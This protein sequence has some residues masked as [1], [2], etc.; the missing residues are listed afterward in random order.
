MKLSLS[1]IVLAFLAV[2]FEAHADIFA[3]KDLKGFEACL[4][5]DNLKESIPA[6]GAKQERFLDQPEIQQR[7]VQSAAKILKKGNPTSA[8]ILEFVKTT[9][10]N[11]AHEQSL[12]LIEVLAAKDPKGCNDMEAYSVLKSALSHPQDYP[13]AQNSYFEKTKGIVKLCSKDAEFKKD[14]LEEKDSA[15]SYVAANACAI[16]LAEK[17]VK[18]CPKK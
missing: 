17:A 12:E 11:S 8:N 5:I 18:S 6:G 9:K 13:S 7:C 16:L 10:R 2:S 3:F 14:F 15:E 1:I 4:R